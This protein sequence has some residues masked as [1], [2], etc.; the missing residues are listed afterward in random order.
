M[1]KRI[2]IKE[3]E[4]GAVLS[5]SRGSFDEAVGMMQRATK[6]EEELSPPSGPPDLIK[7]THE[8]FG[9]ILMQARR[10]KEAAAQFAVALARQPNRARSLLGAARAAREGGDQRGALDAYEDLLRVWRRADAQLAGVREAR[11][12][13][14]Q[15]ARR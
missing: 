10:P 9:E 12:F 8:L 5:A 1:G 6:L 4:I 2:E 14:E 11:G 15:S 7:P 13:V 3:L